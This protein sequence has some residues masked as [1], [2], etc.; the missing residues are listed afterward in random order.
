[1][2]Y[3]EH[4]FLA[5]PMASR[6]RG[7]GRKSSDGAAK[8]MPVNKSP[9]VPKS[10]DEVSKYLRSLDER[11]IDIYGIEFA[12]MVRRYAD[13][14]SK[15]TEAVRVIFDT[16]IVSRDYSELGSCVCKFIIHNGQDD[17]RT[18]GSDFRTCLLKQFQKE[19]KHWKEIRSRSI[20]DWLGIFAF[21]CEIYCKIKVSGKQITVVGNAILQNIEN[22]LSNSDLIDA[23]VDTIC[24]KLKVCGKLLEE[25][26]SERV[27]K[28]VVLLRKMVISRES[29]C[30]RRC[31][32]MEVIEMKQLGWTGCLDTF[33]VDA[34][35]DA[36]VEDE[37]EHP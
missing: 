10:I 4:L 28:I 1:M 32:T 5:E 37:I 35:A 23:E 2:L 17:E 8:A 34:L 27:E 14:E 30:Q 7:R 11:N 18:F 16:T 21:L 25:Q 19:F 31:L 3:L 6:G 29:S 20:E 36:I 9:Q 24:T 33:Y 22:M 26:D 13:S 12:D 15:L